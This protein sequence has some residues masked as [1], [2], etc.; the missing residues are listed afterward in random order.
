MP[1]LRDAPAANSSNTVTQGC[2]GLSA[3]GLGYLARRRGLGKPARRRSLANSRDS[4]G[5]AT[6]T[7]ARTTPNLPLHCLGWYKDNRPARILVGP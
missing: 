5:G 6:P 2:D 3:R 1:Q 4:G 7:N